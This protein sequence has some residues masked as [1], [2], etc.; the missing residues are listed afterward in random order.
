MVR[1]IG[2]LSNGRHIALGTCRPGDHLRAVSAACREHPRVPIVE[3]RL[4][5]L[6]I[7]RRTGGA[8]PGMTAATAAQR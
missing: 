6:V 4:R 1:I 5:G 7:L 8:S 2:I 3:A